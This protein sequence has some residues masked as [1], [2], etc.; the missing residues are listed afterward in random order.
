MPSL[1]AAASSP[2]LPLTFYKGRENFILCSSMA[3]F[4]ELLCVPS[5]AVSDSAGG[6]GGGEDGG[7]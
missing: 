6:G 5:S 3:V 4:L 1:P 7:S 2:G